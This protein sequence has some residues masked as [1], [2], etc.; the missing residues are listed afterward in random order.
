MKRLFFPAALLAL[1]SPLALAQATRWTPDPAHSE[2]D[3]A[4]RHMSLTTVHG[5]FGKVT[6]TI[7][8]DPADLAKSSVQ[9]T[10]DVTGV[11]TGNSTRDN[12]LKGPKFFDVAHYPTATFTSTSV[13]KTATGLA[14]TG[15][16]S[17]HGIT[18]PVTLDVEGPDGPITA[19]DHKQHTG[20][21][22][23]ATVSRAAFG[24]AAKVPESVLGDTVKLTIE[25]DAVKD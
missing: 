14:I 12:D 6:G 7:Q 2:V 5:R 23:T 9:V 11:D 18:K 1:A 24:I 8:L 17:L 13:Q 22:G 15:N 16:L 19:M 10:I 3:F 25:L 21:S 20:Y 4:I